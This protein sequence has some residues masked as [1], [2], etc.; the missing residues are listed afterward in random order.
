MKTSRYSSQNRPCNCS[1]Y[2]DEEHRKVSAI[3][4][5][6]RAM[7]LTSLFMLASSPSANAQ[8][9]TAGAGVLESKRPVE[10][11]VE[12]HA[13]TPPLAST[14]GYVTLSWTDDSA[15]P[16]VITAAERPVFHF[17]RAFTGLGAGLLWLEVND[18]EPYPML[19]SSTVVPLPVPRTSF[20][21]IA[22]TLPFE[23]FD[24]SLVLKVGVTLVFIR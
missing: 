1:A 14:R 21:L 19:V 4:A 13:E 9:V 2:P 12:L 17:G 3:M 6:V 15:N 18:Y 10:P 8:F 22:S 16:T 7:L 23:D 5:L 11:V 24:W 20:V